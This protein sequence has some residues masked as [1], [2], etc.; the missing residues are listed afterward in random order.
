MKAGVSTTPCRV[1]SRPRRAADA[2]PREAAPGAAGRTS[3]ASRP[4]PAT[5]GRPCDLAS[6]PRSSTRVSTPGG[7]LQG[8]AVG[9][10]RRIPLEVLEVVA[11]GV[12]VRLLVLEVVGE[13]ALG[14]DVHPHRLDPL[15]DALV[16][17]EQLQAIRIA[18]L[19]GEGELDGEILEQRVHAAGGAQELEDLVGI[20]ADLQCLGALQIAVPGGHLA[21]ANHHRDRSG[22]LIV[23]THPV[24]SGVRERSARL[25]GRQE[26][27]ALAVLDEAG[28]D[29]PDLLLLLLDAIEQR[30][31]ALG[32][33]TA[34]EPAD[35]GPGRDAPPPRARLKTSPAPRKSPA[36]RARGAWEALGR[37]D[38]GVSWKI[39]GGRTYHRS[40]SLPL[41]ASASASP[42]DPGLAAPSWGEGTPRRAA[43]PAPRSLVQPAR[44]G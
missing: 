7:S 15:L 32:A 18:L 33:Q 25:L 8:E 13:E 42:L 2:T 24:G 22:N 17:R 9:G 30:L 10:E 19:L 29:G 6:L 1:V 35:R 26:H 3:K 20:A 34:P 23:P 27:R 21:A 36:L 39:S 31:Q 16:S 40:P 41:H 43:S 11:R 5:Y 44:R 12:A 28:L 37:S 38:V 14:I 4:V